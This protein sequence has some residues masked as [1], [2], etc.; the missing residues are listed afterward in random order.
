MKRGMGTKSSNMK[1][2]IGTAWI[3]GHRVA[4]RFSQCVNIQ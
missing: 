2:L 3:G 1:H 4:D